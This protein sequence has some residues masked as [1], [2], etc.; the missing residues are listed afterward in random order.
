MYVLLV[1]GWKDAS[2]QKTVIT[3][4]KKYRDGVKMRAEMNNVGSEGGP[5]SSILYTCGYW[6]ML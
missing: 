5:L 1:K 3:S 2:K 6:D 4:S